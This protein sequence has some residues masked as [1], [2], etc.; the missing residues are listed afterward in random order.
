LVENW[1]WATVS[2]HFIEVRRSDVVLQ[3]QITTPDA[4]GLA[5]SPDRVKQASRLL[6]EVRLRN[7]LS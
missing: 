1:R 6:V 7:S 3:P 2:D 5:R 4:E